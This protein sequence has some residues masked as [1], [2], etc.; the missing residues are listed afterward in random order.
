MQCHLAKLRLGLLSNKLVSF[1]R[2]GFLFM[3]EIFQFDRE[4]YGDSVANLQRENI[5]SSETILRGKM[6]INNNDGENGIKLL[7][8]PLSIS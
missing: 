6:N 5:Y 7:I 8:C 1:C 4:N 3:D 2:L